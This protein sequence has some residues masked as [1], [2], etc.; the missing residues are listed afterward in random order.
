VDLT[1]QA[2][3]QKHIDS[4][5]QTHHKSWLLMKTTKLEGHKSNE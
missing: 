1:T 3:A 4:D 5:K 2:L